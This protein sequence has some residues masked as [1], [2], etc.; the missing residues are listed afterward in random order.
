MAIEF[1]MKSLMAH[2]LN[3]TFYAFVI[4]QTLKY[5]NY[6]HSHEDSR[7][8]KWILSPKWK[9]LCSEDNRKCDES[10]LRHGLQY[11]NLM[12]ASYIWLRFFFKN[13]STRCNISWWAAVINEDGVDIF[14]FDSE[15]LNFMGRAMN[16][17]VAMLLSA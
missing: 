14:L 8:P 13:E 5:T 6:T 12:H 4:L 10:R 7:V 15:L 2:A 1:Q 3:F 9:T 16:L 11:G 17:K